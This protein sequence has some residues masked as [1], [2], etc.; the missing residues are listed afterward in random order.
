M[1][2]A[3]LRLPQSASFATCASLAA[4]TATSF[5]YPATRAQASRQIDRLRKLEEQPN[6]STLERDGS[7]EEE[8]VYATAVHAHRGL[9][10]GLHVQLAGGFASAPAARAAE[11][12]RP[13]ADRLA[14]YTV[15]DGERVL[16][17]SPQRPLDPDR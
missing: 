8:L 12:V 17:A 10:L 15:T 16:R 3:S 14:R 13:R 11:R 6:A 1:S 4:R 2:P 5:A 9:G 7:V